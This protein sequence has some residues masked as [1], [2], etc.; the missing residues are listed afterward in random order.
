M[1]QGIM[2]HLGAKM[3]NIWSCIK[4]DTYYMRYTVIIWSENM[5]NLIILIGYRGVGKTT[6]GKTLAD[7]L[8]YDFCDTDRE[9]VQ[10]KKMEI[11]EIV[12]KEGWQEFRKMEKKILQSLQ[13]RR[14]TVA[15]TGGGAVLHQSEW[16]VLRQNAVVIWLTADKDI[17]FARI[18]NDDSSLAQRPSLTGADALVEI[19]QVLR[20]RIP[21]YKKTA[22]FQ[23][24]TGKFTVAQSVRQI[25]NLLEATH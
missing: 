8:G 19:D 3:G 4:F 18:G 2:V 11:A 25:Q 17:L 10:Q 14:K 22:H 9:I 15:A 6:I 5:Y 12:E 16:G 1:Q 23:I 21:L 24:D 13:E 20:E 7:A